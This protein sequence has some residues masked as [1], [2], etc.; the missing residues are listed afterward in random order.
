MIHS[1]IFIFLKQSTTWTKKSTKIPQFHSFLKYI[2]YQDSIFHK[3][4][5]S[6]SL[7]QDILSLP[8]EQLHS[9]NS[10]TNYNHGSLADLLQCVG[11]EDTS[12]ALFLATHSKMALPKFQHGLCKLYGNQTEF[13][14]PSA[15]ID[16]ADWDTFDS[17]T[18]YDIS[19]CFHSHDPRGN[20]FDWNT[21]FQTDDF[22]FFL[23]P[24]P[25]VGTSPL[26][27]TNVNIPV[28]TQYVHSYHA[29]II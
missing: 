16:N 3:I 9:A 19:H 25:L 23:A 11:L 10:M 22:V 18:V 13:L 4:L 14:L 2:S 27:P 8:C 12:I 29:D 6:L 15:L 28:P 21:H 26:L 5:Q 7:H 20:V 1:E 17:D 24:A